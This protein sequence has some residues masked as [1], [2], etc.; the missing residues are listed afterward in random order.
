MKSIVAILGLLVAGFAVLRADK[1]PGGF[2]IMYDSEAGYCFTMTAPKGWILDNETMKG[3]GVCAVFY[4]VGESWDKSETVMYVN[5]RPKPRDAHGIEDAVKID[6]DDMHAHGSSGSKAAKIGE[7]KLRDGRSAVIYEYTGD[8]GGN[9]ER[10]AFVM[11]AKG[12]DAVV[13]SARSRKALDAALPAFDRLVASYQFM[14]PFKL[15]K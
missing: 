4:P 5:T 15:E 7:V 11:E 13:I 3:Q 14:G 12:I 10:T 2:G 8:A 9:F 1:L 6:I